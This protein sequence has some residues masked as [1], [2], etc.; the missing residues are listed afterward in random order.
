MLLITRIAMMKRPKL[1][2]S[3]LN[4]ST[5]KCSISQW[6]ATPTANIAGTTTNVASSGSSPVESVNW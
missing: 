1:S 3:E 2:S 5:W 4:S 6:I